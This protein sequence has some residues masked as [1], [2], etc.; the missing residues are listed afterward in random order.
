MHQRTA[1]NMS[2]DLQEKAQNENAWEFLG[3]W[4]WFIFFYQAFTYF[5]HQ[6]LQAAFFFKYIYYIEFRP[7]LYHAPTP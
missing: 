2:P 1:A 3:V 7:P 6:S 4:F 5:I